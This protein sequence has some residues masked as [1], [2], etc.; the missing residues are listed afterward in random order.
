MSPTKLKSKTCD[1]QLQK[2]NIIKRIKLAEKISKV[3]NV[4]AKAAPYIG[5]GVDVCMEIIDLIKVNNDNK[6]FVLL[7]KGLNESIEF[8]TDTIISIAQNA[9]DNY[10]DFLKQFAPQLFD[11]QKY[12]DNQQENIDTQKSRKEFFEKWKEQA[13]DTEILETIT[14]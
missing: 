1:E 14:T 3:A 5:A 11:L 13:I 2:N 10:K 12:L 7:K 9:H 4:V 8:Y 6:R